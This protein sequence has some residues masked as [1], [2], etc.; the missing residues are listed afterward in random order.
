LLSVRVLDNPVNTY[1]EVIEACTRALPV[2]A[3]EAFRIAYTI[4][5]AGSCVV[6]TAPRAEAERVAAII[7]RIGIEVRLEPCAPDA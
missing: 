7:Q 3:R 6:C 2:S 5:H 4:D 1:Q